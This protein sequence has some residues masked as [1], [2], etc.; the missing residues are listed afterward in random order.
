MC[1]TPEVEL[2]AAEREHEWWQQMLGVHYHGFFDAN[3]K[4]K[5]KQ[6]RKVMHL[7]VWDAILTRYSNVNII[8]AHVGLSKELKNLHPLV[9]MHVLTTMFERHE[10]LYAD[11]S[12]DVLPKMLLMNYKND[13]VA[14]LMHTSHAD[15]DDKAAHL[16]NKTAI[17]ELR[18]ELHNDIWMQHQV[19][20]SERNTLP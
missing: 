19:R 16:F 9:H 5:R 8:W 7:R 20:P 14:R 12:W 11:V 6:F 15:F 18:E 13:S 3:N 2:V 4:P 17:T 10:N 1:E